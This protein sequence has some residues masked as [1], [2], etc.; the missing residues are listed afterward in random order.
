MS[1]RNGVHLI[2]LPLSLLFLSVLTTDR[3]AE[4]RTWTSKTGGHT[5]EAELVQLKDDGNVVLKT[6]AGR[7]I[8]VPISKL[9]DADQAYAR[10]Q[11]AAT[12]PAAGQLEPPKSP[13]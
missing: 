6:K 7:T 13:E 3:A 8:E 5:T 10:K 9:S 4:T 1:F 11:S 2:A 12:P